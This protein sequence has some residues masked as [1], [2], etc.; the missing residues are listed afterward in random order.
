MPDVTVNV[1]SSS[2]STSEPEVQTFE[3]AEETKQVSEEKLDTSTMLPEEKELAKE[4]GFEIEEET[5]GEHEEQ[6]KPKTTEDTKEEEVKEEVEAVDTL[7]TFDEV[8]NDESLA[9]KYNPNEKALYWKWKNDKRK[10]QD[11][12][13]ERDDYKAQID[14]N[15][16][17]DNVSA[18]K[19]NEIKSA[20][21][22]DDLTVEMI[23][24]II[25]GQQ[26]AEG[27]KTPLTMGDLKKIEQDKQN[28]LEVQKNKDVERNQRILTTEKIG[29]AK[30]SNFDELVIA[31]QEVVDGDK[32]NTYAEVLET[33]M[34]DPDMSEEALI[35][36]VITIAKL[37]PKFEELTKSVKSEDTKNVNRAIKNSNKKIS[38]AA[39]ATGSSKRMVNEDELTP[40]DAVR[41]SV[42]QWSKLKPDTQKRLLMG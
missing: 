9:E 21:A 10:R 4:H 24:S 16:I 32:S 29:K 26:E 11:A 5:D 30:Y 15:T 19:L 22:K 35:D 41:M 3:I 25:E 34:S 13:K 18:R 31:A 37:N 17:K 12:Q 42:S 23:Q 2:D 20:L 8:E 6:P 33:A 38:S 28:E 36:R 1:T 14:L 39:V 7:P 27:D 40:D